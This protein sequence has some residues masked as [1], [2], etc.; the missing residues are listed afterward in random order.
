M[1]RR[2]KVIGLVDSQQL[3]EDIEKKAVERTSK[4]TTH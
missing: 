3:G 1:N 2:R 4:R